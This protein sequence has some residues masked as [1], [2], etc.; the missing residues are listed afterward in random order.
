MPSRTLHYGRL[1]RLIGQI[2]YRNADCTC[3]V[4][5][6][7]FLDSIL[8]L[9]AIHSGAQFTLL[10]MFIQLCIIILPTYM[11]K[12][13]YHCSN[14]PP[15]CLPFF[16]NGYTI[17]AMANGYVLIIHILNHSNVLPRS[18]TASENDWSTLWYNRKKKKYSLIKFSILNPIATAQFQTDLDYN[19][20][21]QILES[22]AFPL[23]FS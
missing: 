9:G 12:I 21:Y 15:I 20:Q 14:C 5:I 3:K 8:L 6:H 16:F 11:G 13:W 7:P 23:L 2:G 4:G 18:W 1:S 17:L 19:S 10:V 22:P